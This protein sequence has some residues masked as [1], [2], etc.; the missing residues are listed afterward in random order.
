MMWKAMIYKEW[1]KTRWFIVGL[2]GVG[3]VLLA[4]VF[5][6]LGK[7]YRLLG[8]AEVWDVI[9]NRH[10]GLFSELS[11]YPLAFGVLMA[12]AQFV[13]E[14]QK[15]RL[16]LTLHLPLPQQKAFFSMQF[17]GAV[18]ILGS[19]ILQLVVFYAYCSI[20]FPIE[21]THNTMFSLLPWYSAG[22]TI[23]VFTALICIEP[24]WTRRIVYAILAFAVVYI[25]Y[26]SNYPGAY[27][28]IWWLFLLIP[29]Y[30]FIFP[31]LSVQRFKIGVQ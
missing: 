22:L 30:V 27:E 18:V 14:M 6:S 26:V 25:S 16:K 24:L 15:K 10:Q 31:W 12:L 20:Y 13:P 28:K 19:F 9:I 29:I 3:V 4:Y 21:I 7:V 17:Y 11:Y 5:I 23:Y 8:M 1:L 2:L